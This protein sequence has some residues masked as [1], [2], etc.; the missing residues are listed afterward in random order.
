MPADFLTPEQSQR[1]GTYTEEPTPEQLE[2][3]FQLDDFDLEFI[4]KGRLGVQRLGFALQLTTLR[5]LG[6][7]PRDVR[8]IPRVVRKFV[9][10]QLGMDSRDLN[11]YSRRPSTLSQHQTQIREKYGFQE[12]HDPKV[13]IPFQ[14][15]LRSRS[16]LTAEPLTSLFDL[17]TG[18]LIGERVQLPFVTTLVR[19]ISSIKE[20]ADEKLYQDITADLGE[21]QIHHLRKTVQVREEKH[22]TLFDELRWGPTRDSANGMVMALS[23]VKSIR[24]SVPFS[25]QLPEGLPLRRTRMLANYGLDAK[26]KY[27]LRLPTQRG[28]AILRLSLNQLEK[29]AVDDSLEIFDQIMAGGLLR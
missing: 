26:S 7:F 10:K 23:R 5:F 11:Q 14:N 9:A 13:Q 6:T 2:K 8:N 21:T 3:F 22:N 28:A 19:L 25:L 17:A 4:Q 24:E 1:Y 16:Y 29:Q 15:F 27:L 20:E 18:W 12:F